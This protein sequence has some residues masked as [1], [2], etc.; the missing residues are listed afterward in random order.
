MNS[1][2]G[3]DPTLLRLAGDAVHALRDA[4]YEEALRL[5]R[6]ALGVLG[7]SASTDIEVVRSKAG[8]LS[9]D[10]LVAAGDVLMTMAISTF[11]SGDYINALP[12]SQL[13]H[14][15]RRH[16]NDKV[17]TAKALV[18]LGW[19]YQ[20]LGLY[21]Q[22]IHRASE[23]LEIL[24]EAQPSAVPG[25]LNVIGRVY[26]D[27]GQSDKAL[28]YARR[29]L[30]GCDH[31]PQGLRDRSTA[32]RIVGQ[33]YHAQ[34][35]LWA[36]EQALVECEQTSDAYGRSL[37][38]LTLGDLYL[39][40][41]RFEE[42]VDRYQECITVMSP[43]MREMVLCEAML[44]LGKVFLAQGSPERA[45][46]PLREAINRGH[47]SGAPAEA[48]KAHAAMA[49]ALK[50]LGRFEEA[51]GHYEAFHEKNERILRELSDHRT[52]ILTV[53]LELARLERDRDIDRL[54]NV[55]LAR[56]YAELEDLHK[57]LEAQAA[58][59][60]H[61]SRTDE[62]TGLPNRRA[63]EER[64]E[65]EL[66]RAIRTNTQVSVLMLDIDDFKQINDT[67]S[68]VVGDSVLRTTGQAISECMRDLDMCARIGG[69]EFVILLP[70][71]DIVGAHVV[72]EKIIE[73][74][75]HLNRKK[76]GID[77]TASIG[78]AAL[79]A[80]DDE[81]SLVARADANLYT[82]KRAGKNR[83]QA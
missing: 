66:Q 72:G 40:Q 14:I 60:E 74:V 12:F 71:T 5:G 7:I 48:A 30:A 75:T 79:D 77:V 24:S 2:Q 61:L 25:P 34:G 35:D 65:I 23:A 78:A 53:E 33:A 22:A 11:R 19:C 26:L 83:V 63:F 15:F 67:F 47:S 43:Q 16:A 39:Q 4:R 44:G 68:H 13:E 76:R 57:K 18:G 56:A 8:E 1:E 81:E 80:T 6:Q 41:R 62:L 52:Q 42:A 38:L 37:S 49:Q 9:P 29:S 51:I 32:L 3:V 28:E 46:G 20:T 36:A 45:L 10:H 54:H 27:L 59:L 31:S 69:E 64:L 70:E 50:E 21:Q 82:A 58:R 73:R 55:E 17:G